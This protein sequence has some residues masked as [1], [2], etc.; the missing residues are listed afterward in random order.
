LHKIAGSD[1]GRRQPGPQ[2]QGPGWALQT[3]SS[4]CLFA[5]QII[6]PA[7]GAY[8]MHL[9]SAVYPSLAGRT[10]KQAI[11]LANQYL[12]CLIQPEHIARFALFLAADDSAMCTAQEITVDAG[13]A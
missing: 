9:Q 12:K 3:Y 4:K 7:G 6:L 8:L 5:S 13:W 2:G 10:E 1:F 11:I